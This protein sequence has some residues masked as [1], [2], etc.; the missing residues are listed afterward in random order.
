LEFKTG[1]YQWLLL[2]PPARFHLS[3]PVQS[4]ADHVPVNG[5]SDELQCFNLSPVMAPANEIH[6]INLTLLGTPHLYW[7]STDEKIRH[8]GMPNE[9]RGT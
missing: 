3:F 5:K 7:V 8:S 6:D 9:R 2:R 4:L 1:H